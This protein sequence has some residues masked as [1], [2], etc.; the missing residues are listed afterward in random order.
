MS[1]SEDS[2]DFDVPPG[3]AISYQTGETFP[4]G[5]KYCQ[6]TVYQRSDSQ[7]AKEIGEFRLENLNDVSFTEG[8]KQIRHGIEKII[9]QKCNSCKGRHWKEK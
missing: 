5:K 7:H 3:H 8:L 9:N 6:I 2:F 4:N 1:D